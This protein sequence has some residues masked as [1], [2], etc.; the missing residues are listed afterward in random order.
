MN[1]VFQESVK[2]HATHSPFWDATWERFL[3]TAFPYITLRYFI[4]R[5]TH[6]VRVADIDGRITSVPFSDGGDVVALSDASLSIELFR[7]DLIE[8]FGLKSMVRVHEYHARA[9]P[10]D[11]SADIIDFHLDLKS[12][13]I[14][15]VRKTLRHILDDDL[16]VGS[17]IR[18]ATASEAGRIYKLYLET[19]HNAGGTAL[20]REAFDELM[21]RDV[22][23]FVLDGTIEAASVFFADGA[24][25]YHFI[26]ASSKV[27]KHVHA[28]HHILF[29]AIKQFQRAGKSGLFLGGTNASSS[30]RT[31]KEGWRGDA[32]R[33]FTVGGAPAHEAA[34]QSPLRA[35]WRLIPAGL[36]PKATK[37][38]GRR[39]F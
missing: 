32:H 14:D 38:V 25:V 4:Y 12:F 39:V 7:A 5:G 13:S 16:P 9:V 11:T 6:A 24:S 1:N 22:F 31:F 28:P 33:I 18:S 27:G 19:M 35:L 8:C 3:V 10:T 30:L 21:G 36:L 15:S 37:L 20:P 26:S 17:E 2:P 23:V 34:R 29:H